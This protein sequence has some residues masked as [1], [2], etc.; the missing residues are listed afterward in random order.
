MKRVLDRSGVAALEM[1]LLAPMLAALLVAVIDF[2]GAILSKARV[3]RALERS[4]EYA[5]L[6]G[7]NAVAWTTIAANAQTIAS[8]VTG[9]FVGTPIVTAVVNAGLGTGSKCCPDNTG[10]HCGASTTSCG[11][12]STPGVYIQVQ[13]QYP[14]R[15]LFSADAYLTGKTLTDSIIAPLQ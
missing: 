13:A 12:G 7:Q 5:T 2:S 11:D 14:I 3:T 9:P 4:A 15:T 8:A 1:A 10:M 6:A